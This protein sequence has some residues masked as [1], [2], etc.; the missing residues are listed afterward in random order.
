[1]SAPNMRA[2]LLFLKLQNYRRKNPQDYSAP[3][4]GIIMGD[5]NPRYNNETRRGEKT[6]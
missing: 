4:C 2:L 6:K 5:S 1:M 3:T